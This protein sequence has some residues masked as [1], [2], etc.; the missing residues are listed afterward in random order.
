M[1]GVD[2]STG[3][4][5]DRLNER[6]GQFS[7][8]QFLKN[9]WNYDLTQ[10]LPPATP[11]RF[12]MLN[13]LRGT[14]SGAKNA[15]EN[16]P[17][18]F[19][20]G[21]DDTLSIP[22]RSAEALKTYNETGVYNPQPFME[23]AM[24]TMGGTSMSAPAGAMGA[25]PVRAAGGRG[26]FSD[27]E[28]AGQKYQPPTPR[29]PPVEL[30]LSTEARLARATEQGFDTSTPL[31]HGTSKDVD[32]KRFKDS[33]H[34]TWTTTEPKEASGYAMQNDSK[35]WVYDTS[36]G[37]KPY[38]LRAVNS[39]DRV[40]P[41]YGKPLQNPAYAE[42]YPERLHGATNYKRAQS[43]WFDELKAKGH[44]G[45]MMG[46][47]RVDFNNA[48]LRSQLA[49]FDPKNEGKGV[50]F[51]AGAGD[52]R[53]SLAALGTNLRARDPAM[54]SEF[55]DVKLRKPVSEMSSER[56]DLNP[57]ASPERLISPEQLQGG[58]LLP[59]QGDRSA[60]GGAVT[61]VGDTQLATPV[62]LQG[63][64]GFMSAPGPHV[65]ASEQGRM[66]TMAKRVT[67]PRPSPPRC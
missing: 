17:Q 15:G 50:I 48:N 34:G 31:Y 25:G 61:R 67:D 32:F 11:N 37:A 21:V 40:L 65:W 18:N 29:S 58:V 47:V 5:A 60:I 63:G 59:A 53:G 12:S 14:L 62:E 41:L 39:A 33:R 20:Q 64:H 52:K 54:W 3:V 6:Y 28:R 46:N 13:A 7:P 43:E 55:S 57:T 38:S 27:L 19:M 44:D 51:G 36:P 8:L 66:T 9:V 45:L 16:L 42:S 26:R 10:H 1:A 30:D 4:A 23:G 56:V 24:L 2:E 22:Q 49:P 35:N